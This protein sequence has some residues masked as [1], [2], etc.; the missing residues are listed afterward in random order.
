MINVSM[1]SQLL[2]TLMSCARLA[3]YRFN[4]NLVPKGT[5]SNSLE[6]G[7]LVHVILE[8]YAKAI[9]NGKNRS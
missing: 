9:I 3:D 7:S 6:A 5:K 2:S 8:H 1:D 4:K